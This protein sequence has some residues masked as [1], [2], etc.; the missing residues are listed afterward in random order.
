MIL[1]QEMETT[2]FFILLKRSTKRMDCKIIFFDVDGTL[3]NYEDGSI[4]S[5]TKNALH[6]LKNKGIR[7]VAAT[8]RPLSMCHELHELGIDTFITANGAYVRHGEQIIHTI[9]IAQE[10]VA[11]VKDFADGHQHSLTFF[12]EQLSMNGIQ[13]A[14]T[15]KA[16][17]ETLSLVAYPPINENIVNEQ[18]YL[19]CLYVDEQVE[20]TYITQFPNLSF[21]RWHPMITNV[22]QNDVSKSIAVKAVLHYFKLQPNE[23]IAF[24]DGDN[25][26]DMLEQVGYGVAMGN[27]SVA[28]K[29]IADYVTMTSHEGGIDYAL[30]KLQLI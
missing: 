29:N 8:G 21:E 26:I 12:T 18:V 16:M 7:L 3:I 30:R 23:A 24:G 28:L 22:L 27:G 1:V 2:V 5:S 14:T 4:V 19:M 10:V 20:K 11:S 25:D 13:H 6:I 15:L 9:P 17:N